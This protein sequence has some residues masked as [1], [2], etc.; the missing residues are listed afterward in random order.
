MIRRFRISN[1]S[2]HAC[3]DSEFS[4]R[5]G[6]PAVPHPRVAQRVGWGE[7]GEPQRPGEKLSMR[8]QVPG[9]ASVAVGLKCYRD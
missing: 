8:E 6:K 2:I 3:V 1:I 7:R 4:E 9:A 5:S